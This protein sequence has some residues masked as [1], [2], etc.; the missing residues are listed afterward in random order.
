M[1]SHAP[2][3]RT[4][5]IHTKHIPALTTLVVT[6]GHIST[7]VTMKNRQDERRDVCEGNATK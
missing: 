1:R 4:V 2:H 3:N 6:H 7:T 5:Q